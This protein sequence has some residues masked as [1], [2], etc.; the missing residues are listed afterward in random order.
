M[1]ERS[2]DELLGELPRPVHPDSSFEISLRARLAAELAADPDIVGAPLHRYPD[3]PTT[4]EVIELQTLTPPAT[5]PGSTRPR[6]VWLRAAAVVIVTGA[7][8]TGAVALL[9]DDSSTITSRPEITVGETTV[10]PDIA[11]APDVT[12]VGTVAAPGS[13]FAGAILRTFSVELERNPYFVAADD[14]PWVASLA[15]ELVRL[16][17]ETGEIVARVTV[18]E[19]SPIAVDADAVWVADAITGDVVRLDPTDGRLVARIATGVEILE[20][21]VRFPMLEGAA[22][23]FASIGGI[24]ST[25][26]SVWVGDRAGAVMRIDPATNTITDTFEV[27]V[28]PDH[29]RADGDRVLVANPRAGEAAVLDVA[30]REVI[31]QFTGTDD[32]AGAELYDGAMYLQSA[33]DGTVTRIDLATGEQ[34]TSLPL[35]A[36]VKR[37]HEPTLPTGLVVS[38]AGVLVDTANEP[39]SL[40][41][42]DP[43]TL[44]ELGALPVTADHGDMT[45]AA[46]GSAWLV[47]T[48][49]GELVHITPRAL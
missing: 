18:S 31:Q 24:T 11:V 20:N 42:L 9:K 8:L 12:V 41:V 3:R 27:P 32:L 16:D 6:R 7:A 33:A 5:S 15:G 23:S 10:A 46:D 34:R 39:D 35:G 29:I 40:H 49:T 28:R 37:D 17:A 21:S 38:G 44:A 4:T 25:G 36:S 26:E 2:I 30:S 48:K 19:S 13:T 45:L 1:T 47:R 14:G 22:R 43:V